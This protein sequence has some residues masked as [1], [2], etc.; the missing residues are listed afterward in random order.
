[1]PEPAPPVPGPPEAGSAETLARLQEVTRVQETLLAS[2]RELLSVVERIAI[3]AATHAATS[4]AAGDPVSLSAG[5][6]A[7]TQS[8]RAFE[9]SLESLPGVRAVEVRGFD[10][11]DR[12][13][14]DVH[15]A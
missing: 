14:L 8:L 10:G 11:A 12:A 1:M 7:S 3:P 9:R 6:F 15:L 5:P 2:L 4:A 13:I